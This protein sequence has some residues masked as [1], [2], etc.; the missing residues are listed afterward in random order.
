MIQFTQVVT[1]EMSDEHR[2]VLIGLDSERELDEFSFTNDF[3][4]EMERL[5]IIS[6]L[7]S[8]SHSYAEYYFTEL[9]KQIKTNFELSNKHG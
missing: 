2:K 1:F 3:V 9:G 8:D 5:G 6:N 7:S 4:D